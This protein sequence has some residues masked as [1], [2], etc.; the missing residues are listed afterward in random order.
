[1]VTEVLTGALLRLVT[2]DELSRQID[3]WLDQRAARLAS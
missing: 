3:Q 2:A 1:M